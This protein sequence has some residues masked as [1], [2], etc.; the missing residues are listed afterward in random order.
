MNTFSPSLHCILAREA[1]VGVVI[2][3]GPS[4]SVCMLRW[5]LSSDS[6]ELGQWFRGRILGRR[7]DISPDGRHFLYLAVKRKWDSEGMGSWTAIS[8]VPYLKALVLL[9]RDNC[10]QGGGLFVSSKSY[11]INEIDGY[12]HAT[13]RDHAQLVRDQNFQPADDFGGGCPAVYYN[14][15]LRDG[16]TLRQE[17]PIGGAHAVFDKP[18]GHGLI[19]RKFCWAEDGDHDRHALVE[20]QGQLV[21]DFPHWQWADLD[22]RRLVWAEGG[23]LFSAYVRRNGIRDPRELVDF[24]GMRCEARQAPY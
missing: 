12:R 24:S 20:M 14:R 6:F 23:R 11:W 16:W 3:R 2:R 9:T 8:R 13:L 1:R 17:Q 21:Q 22:R 10:W 7:S 18:V 4:K 5:D 19:L 15:L